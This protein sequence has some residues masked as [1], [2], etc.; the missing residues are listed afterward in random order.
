MLEGQGLSGKEARSVRGTKGF[1][2]DSRIT[3]QDLTPWEK[4]RGA[5][6]CPDTS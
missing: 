2:S 5:P 6:D 3:A 4:L 1:G